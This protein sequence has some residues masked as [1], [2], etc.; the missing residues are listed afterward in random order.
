MLN[1]LELS[2]K[3]FRSISLGRITSNN[4]SKASKRQEKA[5]NYRLIAEDCESVVK[6]LILGHCEA[7]KIFVEQ[8]SAYR[9]NRCNTCNLIVLTQH[10]SEAS[11]GSEIVGLARVDIEK[12]FSAVCRIGLIDKPS[13][14]EY[15]KLSSN[16]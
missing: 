12:A 6:S 14:I 8:Q 13:K 5:E 15:R 7:T 1:Y 2:Q 10:M 4:N 9:A 16:G 3:L 11:Q